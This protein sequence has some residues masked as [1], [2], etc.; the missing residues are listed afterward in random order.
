MQQLH[1][2]P[3]SVVI[4]LMDF[5]FAQK[6]LEMQVEYAPLAEIAS[7]QCNVNKIYTI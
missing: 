3:I 2:R 4:Y 7:L 1:V 6:G 5:V